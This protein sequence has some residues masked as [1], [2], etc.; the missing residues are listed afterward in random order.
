MGEGGPDNLGG[1]NDTGG[2][3]VDH[4]LIGGVETL[5]DVSALLDVV[6]NHGGVQTSIVGNRVQRPGERVLDNIH[7]LLLVLILGC[8]G[9]NSW[10]TSD[11]SNSASGNNAFLHSGSGGVESIGHTILLLV[12]LNLGRS[13]DLEHGHTA[14]QPRHPLLQL[15]LLVLAVGVLDLVPDHV[16]PLAD[17]GLAA[18]TL[19][20]HAVVLGDD[21]LAARP[22]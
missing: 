6:D 5:V 9:I 16:D 7:S 12:D 1:V 22:P 15:L 14:G 13:S 11:Q 20:Q 4:L 19:Q 8:D 17:V 10:Q 2:D 21:H 3:H 18:S